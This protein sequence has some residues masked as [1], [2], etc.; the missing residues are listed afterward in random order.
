MNIEALIDAIEKNDIAAASSLISSGVLNLNQKPWPLIDAAQ[1]NRDEILSLLLDAGADIN[2]VDWNRRTACHAAINFDAFDSLKLLVRRGANLAV[3]DAAG[4]SLFTAAARQGCVEQYILLLLDAGAPL[5]NVTNAYVLQSVKSVAV[6]NRLVARN[7][8]LIAMQDECGGM[9]CHFVARYVDRDDD[10]LR[11]LI[12]V[13]G[14]DALAAVDDDGAAPLHWAAASGNVAAMRVLIELGADI[15]RQTHRGWTALHDAL[16]TLRADESRVELLLALGANVSLVNSDGQTACHLAAERRRLSA[17]GGCVAAGGNL[18]QPDNA[19]N[20]PYNTIVE[21]NRSVIDT[22]Q[23]DAARRRIATIRLDLVR[24]R[25]F[26]IC[27]GLQPLNIDALQLCEI[28]MHSFGA[29]G[30]VIAFH[31]WWTIA[32][33]VKHFRKRPG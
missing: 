12:N 2:V 27:V 33:K 1:H 5:D 7:F 11:F 9:L 23:I 18:H 31:Q 4:E 15:D 14:A 28:M 17:L 16:L 3:V 20:T 32:T 6:F 22:D 25:A 8:D 13:C 21:R 10:D 26:Q 29:I 30:S 19:G 24:H